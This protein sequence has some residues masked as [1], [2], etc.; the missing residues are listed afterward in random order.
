[1]LGQNNVLLEILDCAQSTWFNTMP[2]GKNT[3]ESIPR[4]RRYNRTL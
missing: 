2:I 1:M 3:Y 4:K